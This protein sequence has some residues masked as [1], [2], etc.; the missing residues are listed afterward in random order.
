MGIF[1]RFAHHCNHARIIKYNNVIAARL[2]RIDSIV[3]IYFAENS[4]PQISV[5]STLILKNSANG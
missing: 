4:F 2:Y 1:Y 3:N 5:G